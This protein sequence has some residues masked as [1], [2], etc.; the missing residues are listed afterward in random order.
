[1]GVQMRQ[2]NLNIILL[3]SIRGYKGPKLFGGMG[4]GL[5]ANS[6]W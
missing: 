5:H 2:Q 6:V 3:A 1:M 4:A